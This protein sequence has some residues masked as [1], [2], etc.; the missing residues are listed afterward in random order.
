MTISPEHALK[1]LYAANV[2]YIISYG[3]RDVL[4]L[5]ILAVVAMLTLMPYYLYGGGGLQLDCI[6]WQAVFIAI[7][8]AWI[9]FLIRERRPPKMT[10]DEKRIYDR[11]FH[12]SCTP[13]QMLKLLERSETQTV[14]PNQPVIEKGKEAHKLILI[15]Q[16]DAVVRVNGKRVAKL[17]DGDFIAE[18]NYLSGR[19]TAAEVT[20]TGWLRCLCWSRAELVN[21]FHESKEL[22]SIMNDLIG[23]NLVRKITTPPA[24]ATYDSLDSLFSTLE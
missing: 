11:V 12:E 22:K 16:G 8:T 3:V 13:R 4:W 7:N 24:E 21:L 17:G 18:M 2:L 19:R 5:R 15:D 20:A 1:F 23:R 6:C 9:V 14:A 10:V